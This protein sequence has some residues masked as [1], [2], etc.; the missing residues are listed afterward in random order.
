MVGPSLLVRYALAFALPCHAIGNMKMVDNVQKDALLARGWA[1]QRTPAAEEQITLQIG[2]T[3][4]DQDA[5]IAK[6]KDVSD[7][8]SP[9]YGKYLDRD[10]ANNLAKPSL[11][12][13]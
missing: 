10:D 2:L 11:D 4:Q 3:L 9:N 12:A 7:P 6:L 5:L 1:V 13:S 8:K